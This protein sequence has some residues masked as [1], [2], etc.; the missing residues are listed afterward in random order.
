M[1]RRTALLFSTV[2]L[3]GALASRAAW[4]ES[5]LDGIRISGDIDVGVTLNPS[6]PADGINFGQ[7]Y[8]DRANQVVLNRFDLAAERAPDPA[9]TGLDLGFRAEG[10]FG[11]DSRFN[12]F[13]G[14]GDHPTT[15]R[16]SFDLVEGDI[17]AHAG[18]LTRRGIDLKL[19]FFPTPLG[20]ETLDPAGN[21]FYSHSYIYNFGLPRKHTG[22]LTTTHVNPALDLY[23]GYTTGVNTTFG[24]GGGYDDGQP[25]ILAGFGLDLDRVKIK[26]L[27]HIGAEDAPSQ[28][29]PGVDP[30]KQP[31]YVNDVVIDWKITD[32]LTSVTELNYVRDDGLS[33]QAGG[34][35]EYL[36]YPVSRT[37]TLGLRA[38]FWRD[39]EG[40]FVAGYPGNLDYINAEEG[41]PSGA[42]HPGPATYGALT[43]G[44]NF[45]PTG[46]PPLI[47]GLTVRPEVRY[48][49][50]LAGTGGF[51]DRPGA[52]KD[53]VTVGVDVV[54]PLH[55]EPGEPG[56]PVEHGFSTQVETPDQPAAAAPTDDGY[57]T[58][59]VTAPWDVAAVT[60]IDGQELD[61]AQPRTLE[62]LD[63]YAPNLTIDRDGTAP[64]GAAITLRGIGDVAPAAGGRVPAVGVI[65]DGVPM[66]TGAGQLIDLYDASQVTVER[67]PAGLFG[68]QDAIGG[69]IVVDRARPTRHWGL[70][71]GYGLEQGYHGNIEQGLLNAPVGTDA[72]L[73]VAI[74]HRQRGG[75][76]NNIYTGDGLYGRDEM[77]TG[78]LQFDWSV[79]PRLDVRAGVTLTHE[80]GQ[81]APMALGDPLAARLLGPALSAATPGLQFNGYG[82]PYAPGATQPLGAYTVAD[83]YP[84][85]NLLTS[86]VYSLALAYDSPVGRFASTT[87]YLK[88]NDVT[89]QDL[90][91]SCAVSDLGGAPCEVL[92]NP[93]VGFLHAARS[94]KYDQFSEDLRYSR[95]LWGRAHVAAGL[96]YFHN[97]TSAVDLTETAAAGVP[98][99]APAND[100]V[101]GD[102]LETKAAYAQ[103]G[104]DITSR[105]KI[106]GGVRY[107]D[108]RSTYSQSSALTYSPFIGPFARPGVSPLTAAAG[109]QSTRRALTKVTIDYQVTDQISLY[110]DR[111]DG[112]RPGGRAPF[113]TLSEQIPG[114]SNYDPAN[115]GA[116]YG[117]FGPERVASYEIGSRGAFLNGRLTASAAGF[118][119]EDT[120]RQ[121][122]ETVATPGYGPGFA[123]YVVNIPKVEIKGAEL[124][125]AWRPAWID[126]LTLSGNGGYQDAR[127]THGLVP[128]VQYPANLNATAGAP[129][130]TADLA[131]TALDRVPRFNGML[132]GDYVLKL[133]GGVVD[134]NGDYRWTDRYALAQVAGQSDWQ[135]AYGLVDVAV[136]YSRDFYRLSVAARNLTNRVYFSNA[137]P[138]L[139]THGW[140]EPRTV[141]VSLAVGF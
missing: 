74:S 137:T 70:E 110:A 40:V 108:D 26:A 36:T 10:A 106:S 25:H 38:E 138:A 128:G 44:V 27:T 53:Q 99:T 58:W 21:T 122:D 136:S 51:G 45:R 13:E 127:I 18:V 113:A 135:A 87:A 48:D 71:A 3:A 12:H 28:V 42:F 117:A 115:P 20:Y 63:R 101:S 104:V 94:R 98:A 32:K 107:V 39:A 102:R 14:I 75:Y 123:S 4:A 79:T 134:L 112:L 124:E 132:R 52:D 16:N 31:R 65:V 68:G 103:L 139:F 9:A 80:D 105:L 111:A 24:S 100:V 46:L 43:A 49:R 114:Q 95:D 62:D 57:V 121:T 64:E 66:G 1:T 59:K 85:R 92:G 6:T 82:T 129:G 67:G 83:D 96:Y 109:A 11:S 41:L 130:T 120:D 29:A 140:G 61:H 84:D 7:L 131:G 88:Q 119:I 141:V 2:A 86:Q 93:V 37:V 133:A 97:D 15:S 35:A 54:V 33:A 30:H 55:V 116:N 19:G 60:V 91:G 118:L 8:T 47:D 126:G 77:T 23:L 73:S 34:A 22:V 56:R 81:G 78:A 72:G 89:Q 76:L 50:V 5:W 17:L 125:V 69:E 90:D